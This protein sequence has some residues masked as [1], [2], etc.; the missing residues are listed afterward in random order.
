MM[1]ATGLLLIAASTGCGARPTS[2]GVATAGGGSAGPSAGGGADG[3]SQQELAARYGQCVRDNGLP[4]FPDPKI[5]ANGGVSQDVPPGTDPQKIAAAQEKCRQWAP[6]GG[7]PTKLDP[8]RIEQL[9]ELAQC[10]RDHGVPTFPDPTDQGIQANGNDSGLNPD[11]PTFKAAMRECGKYGPSA[12]PDGGG[13]GTS[14]G[15]N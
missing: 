2:D 5:N 10:M 4:D 12:A 1:I 6:G 14:Q 11:D 8:E 15:G 9:R 13:T 3:L 7:E